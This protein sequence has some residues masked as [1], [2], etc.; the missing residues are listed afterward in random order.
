MPCS[1]EC[2]DVRIVS[3][4]SF[5]WLR[6]SR[7]FEIWPCRNLV[8]ISGLAQAT[9]ALTAT[10]CENENALA[11]MRIQMAMRDVVLRCEFGAA[12]IRPARSNSSHEFFLTRSVQTA[13]SRSTRERITGDGRIV[14]DD[15]DEKEFNIL[16][17]TQLPREGLWQSVAPPIGS[18]LPGAASTVPPAPPVAPEDVSKL[19][20]WLARMR[21]SGDIVC[22][23]GAG[24]STESG[25][26]DYRSPNGAYSAGFK[27]MT[28]QDFM[29]TG[30]EGFQ[31]RKKYWI[32][33]FAGWSS[34][35][36]ME[37]NSGHVALAQLQHGGY[38]RQ[39][40]TQNVDRLHHK[41]G[42]SEE[43][44]LE[45]HGTTHEVRC[46]DC[47][48][49][50]PREDVQRLIVRMNGGALNEDGTIGLANLGIAATLGVT[51]TG[52]GGRA[53]V[54]ARQGGKGE[55]AAESTRRQN[56]DGDVEIRDTEAV[57]FK[58]PVCPACRGGLLKPDVV[59]FGDSL[60]KQ[61]TDE[62]LAIAKRAAGILV[63]GSSLQV[64]SAFRLVQQAKEVSGAEVF[65]VTIGETRAD[66]LADHKVSKLAGELLPMVVDAVAKMS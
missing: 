60:P 49:V 39:I 7:K 14:T 9:R 17:A 6:G 35:S 44:V 65:I 41:A 58:A 66:A 33:S 16:E 23:T 38:I 2:S 8:A 15:A 63:V 61:R 27:P 36:G 37:P 12:V 55:A 25:I 62:S 10:G 1:A 31:N 32:R 13:S 42:S 48:T 24:L 57:E 5:D 18:P 40:I 50:Y 29:R 21:K 47:D 22:I 52:R 11:L 20:G 54:G 43:A 56:P 53:G 4:L 46:M 3:N 19:A 30:S 45:L 64:M 28:H 34:F 26:P 59:F 51:E